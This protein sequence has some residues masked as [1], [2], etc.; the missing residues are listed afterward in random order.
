MENPYLLGMVQR[1]IFTAL[2]MIGTLAAHAQYTFHAD[3]A[4]IIYNE[5]TQCHRT[6]E[7][8]P[9]PFTTYAEVAAYGEFIVYVTASGY[10]PP[11]TPDHTFS[12]LRG[13]RFLTDDEKEV[14]ASWVAAGMPE[15]DPADNPGLPE[16]PEG[17]QVGTPDLV[18]SMPEPFVHQGDM[19][20][21]YQVF[22]IPTG[23]TET[24][25]I[26][27]V[28]VR[29]GNNSVDHHALI[30]YTN[31]PTAVSQAQALD[32]ND[33][34]PG[35]E[36][37]G[38]YGVDVEQF[39]F[40]GWVPGTPPIEFPATLGHV[41]E[42]GSHLLLQMHYGPS[43]VEEVDQT[44]INLFFAD[45]PIQREVETLIVGPQYLDSPFMI[46]PNQITTFH[47]SVPVWEDFSLISITPHCHLLGK[48]WEVFARSADAQDTIPLISIPE[49][50]FNWQG[51]FTFPELVHLPTG[52]VVEAFC[53][54]DNTADNPL[55]PSD[56][57]QWMTWG[58]FTT[59]EM[60]VMFLQGVPYQE[61][62]EDIAMSVPDRNTM[63]TYTR[64]NL[65]PAWPNPVASG[66]QIQL[67]YHLPMAGPITLSLANVQGH[68][69]TRWLDGT[70]RGKGSHVETLD[71]GALPAG[72]YLLRLEAPGGTVRATKLQVHAP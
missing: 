17:S 54:Y 41:I 18:L 33:P 25:E 28:E 19:E 46:P 47:A 72:T 48:S 60:F 43:P 55:N 15:G 20:D 42:P 26:R 23:V 16:F 45:A 56:P 63:L 64:T 70:N 71:V 2:G 34:A 58:D 30:A 66:R 5:C 6:G 29:P 31:N 35:Y 27:A 10:M 9:M 38:D 3:V 7:I 1:K 61:G 8:G 11:W 12:S 36:S 68:E 40:G 51:L 53:T 49:W 57:P 59:D 52:Y 24:K 32:A 44:E 39:L 50:D 62:D 13:E 14:L 65:Y 21:Q 37:F 69:V 4:P 22:V 67:G